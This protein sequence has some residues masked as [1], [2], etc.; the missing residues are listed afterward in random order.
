MSRRVVNPVVAPDM[1]VFPGTLEWANDR[2]HLAFFAWK[3]DAA[4][5][6]GIFYG[7]DAATGKLTP[8]P[9][10]GL[11][12]AT[13]RERGWAQRP[14]R[15]TWIGDRLAVLARALPRDDAPPQFTYRDI[16]GRGPE[17]PPKA[18]WYLLSSN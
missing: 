7:L 1:E 5:R 15:V 18:D 16:T 10:A 14:E 2:N 6:D 8:Y 13:E 9:H 12:L 3:N 11:D 4:V 17:R